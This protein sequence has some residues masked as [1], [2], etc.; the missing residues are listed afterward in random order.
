L[1]SII[2]ICGVGGLAAEFLRVEGTV[3]GPAAEIAAAEFPDEIAAAL[4]VIT[5]DA[6][7]AGVMVEIA[8]L[9]PLVERQDGVARE[10]A[11]AHR[12]NVVERGGIGLL[13]VRAAD[14]DTHVDLAVGLRPDRVVHPAVGAVVDVELRAEGQHVLDVLRAVV[15]HR[16][17]L[18]RKR[19]PVLVAFEEILPQLGPDRLE[20]EAEVADHRIVP[21]DGMPCLVDVAVTER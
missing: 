9:G 16:P 12:R 13:A 17:P 10:R 21:E 19:P 18:A 6:A 7:L 3:F 5:R 20:Q 11:E 8:G 15:D 14:G 2:L 4:A 1:I